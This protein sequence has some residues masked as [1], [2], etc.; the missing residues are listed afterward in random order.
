MFGPSYVFGVEVARADPSATDVES[1]PDLARQI[2]PVDPK[3]T[4]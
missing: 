1:T 4:H 2:N 3:P